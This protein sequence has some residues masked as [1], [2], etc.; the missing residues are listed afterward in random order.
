RGAGELEREAAH[1]GPLGEPR[2]MEQRRAAPPERHAMLGI[3]DRQ[4]G[5]VPPQT[6]ARQET[7]AVAAQRLEIVTQ[8]E[9]AVALLALEAVAR[10]VYRAAV[11]GTAVARPRPLR[12]CPAAGF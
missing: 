10:G 5:G 2:E 12:P 1:P 6:V 8:L 3:G 7:R 11:D 9:Q 4:H